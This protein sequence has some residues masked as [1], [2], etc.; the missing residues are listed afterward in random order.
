MFLAIEWNSGQAGFLCGELAIERS[1]PG[2]HVGKSLGI[3]VQFQEEMM[4]ISCRWT[5][6][7]TLALAMGLVFCTAASG[8]ASAIINYSTAGS[9]DSTGV[10]GPGVISFVPVTSGLF[11]SPSAFS[12]GDF[13]VAP[14]PDGQTTTYTNVPFHITFLANK[15]NGTAPDPNET[16]IQVSGV[17]N[18]TVTGANQAE[19]VATFNPIANANFMTGKLSNT[20]SII[21]SPLSLVPSTTNNGQTS[22]QAG[23]K[24]EDT[25]NPI[26]EPTSIALFVTTLAGLGIR[27]QIR[28]TRR[29]A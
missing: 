5:G 23:L 4:R 3:G 9:I 12:L 2:S 27:Q 22:A 6:L 13:Q 24:T 10:S 25:S 21:D 26:P 16:P 14:L 18:G 1:S 20:L 15:V 17:L 19:V 11:N 28:R 8:E 29:S 7:R